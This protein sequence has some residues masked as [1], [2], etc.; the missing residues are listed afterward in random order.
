MNEE[1]L[2]QA[3]RLQELWKQSSAQGLCAV[4]GAPN[5]AVESKASS[6]TIPLA[7]A[8]A[9]AV[10]QSEGL[11]DPLIYPGVYAPSGFDMMGILIRVRQRPNPTIDIG[12]IDSSVS[13][14]L[15]DPESHDTPIVYCSETF[16]ALTG[17]NSI[18]ILQRNCRFLQQPPQDC[19]LKLE[20][21]HQQEIRKTND[22]AR[23]ELKE[24]FARNEEAQVKLV[25]FTR[26][27]RMFVNLLT[28][29]PIL[30]DED[31]VGG[32]KKR[33]LVGFMGDTKRAS[34]G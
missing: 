29:I 21:R 9:N 22:S 11:G 27:G 6:S 4:P 13:L 2:Q 31:G 1:Y 18:D 20:P 26:D 34:F 14:V 24:R 8:P 23:K 16:E 30:W 15:C 33:Y 17:Y 5:N 3:Q 32:K 19:A 10:N 12:S 7:L 28:V 25:N